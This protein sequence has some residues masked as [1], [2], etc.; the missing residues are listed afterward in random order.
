MKLSQEDIDFYQYQVSLMEERYEVL[1]AKNKISWR[2]YY[3]LAK[4]QLNNSLYDIWVFLCGLETFIKENNLNIKNKITLKEN[5][6]NDAK[7]RIY[8]I[9]GNS[10]KNLEYINS[11]PK[12]E[13]KNEF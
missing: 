11:L 4:K 3:G 1:F 10:K 9:I 6:Y 5:L 12:K 2:D 7:N 13:S 8:R